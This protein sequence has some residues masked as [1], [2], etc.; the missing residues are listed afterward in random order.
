MFI[1]YVIPKYLESWQFMG[2]L[3]KY[4][5]YWLSIILFSI[6][7]ISKG[8]ENPL[9][10]HFKYILSSWKNVVRMETFCIVFGVVLL[11]WPIFSFLLNLF[12]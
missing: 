2:V 12:T 10:M 1:D 6:Q 4:I 11:K 9:A 8:I 5:L 7:V 3:T